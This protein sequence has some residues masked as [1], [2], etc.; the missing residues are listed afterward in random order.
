MGRDIINIKDDKDIVFVFNE[1]VDCVRIE[2]L[3]DS[4]KNIEH[5]TPHE[6]MEAQPFVQ[7]TNRTIR[8]PTNTDKLAD[9]HRV[10]TDSSF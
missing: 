1:L 9:V 10:N 6:G 4:A 2:F 3:I 8:L 5:N 7:V